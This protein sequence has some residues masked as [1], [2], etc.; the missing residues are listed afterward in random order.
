M[1]HWQPCS[2]QRW[3]KAKIHVRLQVI[4][5]VWSTQVCRLNYSAAR[6]LIRDLEGEKKIM[7]ALKSIYA[8]YMMYEHSHLLGSIKNFCVKNL[9]F[10][11][12]DRAISQSWILR[13][14]HLIPLHWLIKA[15]LLPPT[16]LDKIWCC[17][18]VLSHNESLEMTWV[19][20]HMQRQ[21][22]MQKLYCEENQN[23]WGL[24]WGLRQ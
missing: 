7:K 1:S 10:S 8:A 4:E 17:L 23:V 13:V 21:H 14:K 22:R 5:S 2:S 12:H 16:G 24:P 9:T 6:W 11:S 19:G 15:P 18:T 20:L 3:R